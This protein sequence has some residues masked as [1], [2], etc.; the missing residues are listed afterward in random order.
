MLTSKALVSLYDELTEEQQKDFLCELYKKDTIL[1]DEEQRIFVEP[2][3]DELSYARLL[4][5][6]GIVKLLRRFWKKYEIKDNIKSTQTTREKRK[7]EF[8]ERDTQ[9]NRSITNRVE[10]NHAR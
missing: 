4:R 6:E 8:A 7:K 10:I 5:V 3:S 2:W 1:S 9:R